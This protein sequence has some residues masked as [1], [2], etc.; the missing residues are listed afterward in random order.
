MGRLVLIMLGSAAMACA[1]TAVAQRT[2]TTPEGA[3]MQVSEDL[4]YKPG[5]LSPEQLSSSARELFAQDSMNVF[6]RF[7][8]E[9]SPLQV[10][11][12]AQINLIG[13]SQQVFL[14]G[15]REFLNECEYVSLFRLVERF[16]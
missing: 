4:A 7:P 2:V 13:L 8:R 1:G 14:F 16:D 12:L 5:E 15:R 10:V 9:Q 3:Q 6:R 11:D